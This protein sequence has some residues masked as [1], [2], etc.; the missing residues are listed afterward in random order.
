ML[1][2]MTLK[3]NAQTGG[4]E[5]SID[6]GSQPWPLC[7]LGQNQSSAKSVLGHAHRSKLLDSKQPNVY[8]HVVKGLPDW[9]LAFF[10]IA[11]YELHLCPFSPELKL[12]K[13]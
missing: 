5:A 10:D 1:S 3:C 6:T 7:K 8:I 12:V 9:F 4:R 2:K 13:K 11:S